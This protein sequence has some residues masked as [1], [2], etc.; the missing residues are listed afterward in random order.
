MD[1]RDI[2]LQKASTLRLDRPVHLLSPTSASLPC[3]S[4]HD[5]I[6][7][8]RAHN[9]LWLHTGGSS[10]NNLMIPLTRGGGPKEKHASP[11]IPRCLDRQVLEYPGASIHPDV[12]LSCHL[13]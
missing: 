4:S 8:A 2:V 3:K 10:M 7:Y 11:G 12:C 9:G 6:N 1:D 13:K 5:L